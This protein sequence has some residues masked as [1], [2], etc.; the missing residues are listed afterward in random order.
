M[1]VQCDQCSRSYE[2]DVV[3]LGAVAAVACLCGER[4]PLQAT[5][6]GQRLGKY[7]LVQRI[8]VGGM[9]E[10]YY[11]KSAGVAG[12]EKEVA[13][14][15]MLPHLS[16]DPA[17]VQMLVKEAKLTVLLNHPNIVGI[18]DLARQGDEYYI[19]MEY[20]PGVTVSHVLDQVIRA[21]LQI[22]W[23]VAVHI[24]ANVLR[25]LGYAH[26]LTMP[27]GER[28]TIL[29]RD[30][31]P[32]N[33]LVT[34][35]GY[36]KI[37]DFGIAKATNEIS[38]TSPGMIKGKLGYL[39]PEQLT[40][41]EPDQR[42]DLFCAG[43]LLWEMLALRRLFKGISEVDTFRLISECQIPSLTPERQDIPAA[44]AEVIMRGL[45]RDPD[46]RFA[47]GEEFNAALAQAIL[48]RTFDDMAEITR[49]FFTEQETFFGGVVTS[50]S[51][52][53]ASFTGDST[54]TLGAGGEA[55]LEAETEAEVL[56]A[57]TSF[58]ATTSPPAG[59]A[60]PPKAQPQISW[61][62]AFVLMTFVLGGSLT[63]LWLQRG[64]VPV[65]G[66]AAALPLTAER[67]VAPAS[68]PAPATAAVK[69]AMPA[70]APAPAPAGRLTSPRPE[71]P[72]RPAA[73][74]RSVL[75]GSEIQVVV[76]RETQAIQRCLARLDVRQEKLLSHVARVT[77]EPA[78]EVSEVTIS[79]SIDVPEVEQCISRGLRH[80]RFH[81]SQ[82]GARFNLPLHFQAL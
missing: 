2:L 10:I 67:A 74:S 8:A 75:S 46:R 77:I 78:G 60:V 40:G 44:L 54:R 35:A 55:A 79:P 51:L 23:E 45:A 37:T 64:T 68:P 33:I 29:H 42:A 28:V 57:V 43:I 49:A 82:A 30:I 70:P 20:V 66:L 38:T 80:M 34:Q 5:A 48:P 19:A 4:L 7:I 52:K 59:T 53:R 81:P 31:T 3:R 6:G 63:A 47:R 22:P 41:R 73:E 50:A 76:Q 71:R 36:V 32:Q 27:D 39:A 72:A 9:G 12:F 17:F 62:V 65:S 18:Y 13:I 25:G 14:K 58:L 69:V 11:G 24:T 16:Q 26:N 61:I 15:R 21:Q 56:P 1:K